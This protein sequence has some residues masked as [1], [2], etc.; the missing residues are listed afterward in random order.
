MQMSPASLRSLERRAAVT[1]VLFAGHAAVTLLVALPPVAR[2]V[3]LEDFVEPTAKQILSMMIGLSVLLA[4]LVG[5][6][7]SFLMWMHKAAK[8]LRELHPERAFT[9]STGGVV[10]WWF[11]PFANFVKPFQAMH[12]IW[13]ASDPDLSRAKDAD[14]YS[15]FVK[16]GSGAPQLLVGWWAAWIASNI[17]DRVV[18][19]IDDV[20]L[21]VEL[22]AGTINLVAAALA[23]VVVRT[24]TSMQRASFEQRSQGHVAGELGHV[25]GTSPAE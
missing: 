19:R 7:V 2:A 24:V 10:G 11:V 8:N 14:G 17:I 1:S 21:G 20:G 25:V 13:H 18:T 5:T 4:V 23:I 12:E 6:I 22:F 15:A 16:L 3:F 9:F